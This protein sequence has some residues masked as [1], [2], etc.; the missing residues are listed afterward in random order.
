MTRKL[1]EL[2]D[3]IIETEFLIIGGGLVGSMAAIRAK[4]NN[5]NMDVTIIDKA[6]MEYSGD[7]V[8][9]DNFNQVP[10]RKEDINKKVTEED[11]KKSVFGAERMKG[12]RDLKLDAVQAS[13]AYISQPI[14]EEIG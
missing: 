6:R 13:N 14:L 9:L 3:G 11:A 5:K 4:K 12:L 10:L 2:A 7:G 1:E 8:G